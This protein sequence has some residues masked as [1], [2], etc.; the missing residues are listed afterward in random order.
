MAEAVD[1]GV[2]PGEMLVCMAEMLVL[3]GKMLIFHGGNAGFTWEKHGSW[4]RKNSL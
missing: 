4:P 3:P 2:S 1:R